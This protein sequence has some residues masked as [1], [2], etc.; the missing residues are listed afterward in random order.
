MPSFKLSAKSVETED[1]EGG[2]K[3]NI[4]W[5]LYKMRKAINA[6]VAKAPT[7]MNIVSI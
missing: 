5:L 4:R 2:G 3:V 6:E 7:S 1:T